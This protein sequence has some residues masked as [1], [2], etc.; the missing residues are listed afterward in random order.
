MKWPQRRQLFFRVW[1]G[2]FITSVLG[3]CKE[4]PGETFDYHFASFAQ[5]E[6]IA[7]RGWI[8]SW[9]PKN[10]TDIFETHNLDSNNR[11]L[12]FSFPA[13]SHLAL[14]PGCKEVAFTDLPSPPFERTWWTVNVSDSKQFDAKSVF[15]DC[16]EEDDYTYVALTQNLGRAYVWS[17]R[18]RP[19]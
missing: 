19:N 8:P 6:D 13:D 14:P 9:V 11:M 16:S 17:Y 1:I 7:S 10:A 4:W 12:R 15:F 5:A 18:Y 2:L 3:G